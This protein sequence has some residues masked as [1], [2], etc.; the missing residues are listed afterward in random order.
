[1]KMMIFFIWVYILITILYDIYYKLKTNKIDELEKTIKE[2][3]LN[4]KYFKNLFV[5]S[6]LDIFDSTSR[7]NWL[8]E[9]WNSIYKKINKEKLSERDKIILKMWDEIILIK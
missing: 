9:Y 5:K 2:I 7:I 1:M 8:I 4:R 6:E 3:N